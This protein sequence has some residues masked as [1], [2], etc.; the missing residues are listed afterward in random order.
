MKTANTEH[1]VRMR[2]EEASVYIGSSEFT[3][4]DM[5]RRGLIPSY[6]I[7]NK[8]MFSKNTLDNWI[9]DQERQS[10]TVA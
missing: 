4:R 1:P 5:A 9:E 6:R 7:G 3:I 10:M 2:P 8:I